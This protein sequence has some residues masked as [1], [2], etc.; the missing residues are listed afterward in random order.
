M[1]E[2]TCSAAFK[3]KAVYKP[4]VAFS[5][6]KG[7]VGAYEQATQGNQNK[8]TPNSTSIPET[9]LGLLMHLDKIKE[10]LTFSHC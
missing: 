10:I 7:E 5:Q 4:L 3:Y 9:E 1:Q 2:F 8:E 6:L